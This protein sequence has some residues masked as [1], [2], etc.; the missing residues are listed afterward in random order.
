MLASLTTGVAG[1]RTHQLLLEVVGNNL[2]NVN[3]PSFKSSR[4]LFS[5]VLSE[6]L[7][8]AMGASGTRGGTNPVQR[9][10]GVKTASIDVDDSQGSLEMT[11]RNL[12]LA[13][14]GE[15]FFVVTDCTQDLYTR[16]GTFAIDTEGKLVHSSTGYRV[17]DRYGQDIQIP[18]NTRLPGHATQTVDVT[19]N[20]DAGASPPRTEQLTTDDPFTEGGGAATAASQLNALDSNLAAYVDGDTIEIQGIACDGSSVAGA[21]TYGAANDGTTLGE[22]AACID[23]LYPAADCTLDANGDLLL[24]AQVEGPASLAVT[25]ADGAAS[26]ETEPLIAPPPPGRPSGTATCS[27]RA[28][29]ASTAASGRAR[30]PSSTARA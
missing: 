26:T 11:G 12:D 29:R 6:T 20:L 28:Q 13:I 24:T 1:L 17:V 21:F 14:G 30:S 16:V 15:G 7:R 25:I 4:V 9:G 22:L 3:T 18:S 23:S 10:L 19:G 2:A 27:R 8:P 5:D